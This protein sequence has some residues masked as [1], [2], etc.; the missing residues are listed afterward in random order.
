MS[1][2]QPDETELVARA[3]A[4]DQS[5]CA[6]IVQRYTGVLY[7]QA[8]RMLGDAFEAEDAVQEVF[9]RAFRN[10]QSYDPSRRLVTWLLTIGSNYCIDRLRRR[11]FNWL[12]L[13]DVAFW[14]PST[15]PGPE[16]SA[17][18]RAQQ[19]VVQRALQRLPVTYRGVTV[20]RY[21]YDLSYEEIGQ[22]LGLT[23]ATVKTRLH[24][25]RKMLQEALA[26]EEEVWNIEGMMS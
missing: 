15:Q 7:N 20:L 26:A 8:Y 25:A 2:L 19:E 23:E 5:A 22:V 11:R 14:L 9:L 21:W 17:L 16:R 1:E 24:R 6:T 18:Q 4:G 13:E 12:T 3:C 10:L